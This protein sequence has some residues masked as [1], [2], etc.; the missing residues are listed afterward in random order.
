MPPSLRRVCI[1]TGAARGIG[2]ATALAAGRRG[3]AV[4][5]NYAAA[6]DAADAIVAQ[7]LE[8]GG[9]AMSYRADV[10][11]AA[12]M[13]ALFAAVDQ[14]LGA[15]AALVCNAGVSGGRHA[16]TEIDPGGFQRVVDVN[17]RGT[18]LCI[19][20]ATRRM[21]RSR[22]GAGG[23]IVTMSSAAV[24]TGGRQIASYV[25]AKAG[26]EALTRA[27]GPELASE[28]IRINTVAPGIIATDQQPL[29]DEAWRERAAASVPLGR[30]GTAREVADAILWLLSDDAAYVTGSVLDV[31]GGR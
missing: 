4:C 3:Y 23:A 1:V 6:Q 22:G 2:A 15:V 10:A 30:I 26:V 25:A 31:T 5:V 19:Q 14:A 28:G 20:E 11:S 8:E 18:F 29:E 12:E 13:T 24:R 7:I 9:E 21:A 16:V 27:L 17:L